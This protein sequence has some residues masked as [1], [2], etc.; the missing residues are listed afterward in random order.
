MDQL[1]MTVA[2]FVDAAVGHRF[3]IAR[4]VKGILGYSAECEG[5]V[6]YY[7]DR[8]DVPPRLR[9]S[10]ISCWAGDCVFK[11]EE[12]NGSILILLV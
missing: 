10:F 11:N 5:I 12:Y 6:Y 4:S 8:Y 2:Q 7:G 1:K 9:S 3:V